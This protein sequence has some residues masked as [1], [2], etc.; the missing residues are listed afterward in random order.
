M[1]IPGCARRRSRAAGLWLTGATRESCASRAPPARESRVQSLHMTL[2]LAAYFTRIGY[3]GPRGPNL[4]VL[5][6]LTAAHAQ[7]IPF[8]NLD[9][10]L[11]R[12]ID[13]A[14]DAVFDKLVRRRRGGYCFEHNA[15]FLDVLTA[16]GFAVRPLSAR[17]RILPQVGRTPPRTHMFLEVQ[18][19]GEHWLTDVGVGALSLTSAI[20]FAIDDEQQTPHEPR[21]IIR[22][23]EHWL[24]QALLID[25]WADVY[26]F[27]GEEMPPI[28][29]E[30][31]N[32]Y[33]SA[34]PRSHFR[35]FLIVARAAPDGGRIS[36]RDGELK[37]RGRHGRAETRT[38][39]SA[40]ELLAVLRLE[41]DLAFPPGTRFGEAGAA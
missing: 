24:H 25:T 27:T 21:R 34:H 29:R 18:I 23:A 1:R 31:G 28:D 20:R 38:I 37:R 3:R 4:E 5:N 10:L 11:G 14:P 36:L 9:V 30:V 15:L 2:D 35:N 8:E 16:L 17:G 40:E 39:K 7:A 6:A 12:G 32:W 19:G 22:E 26:E 13:L 33:T 41:F